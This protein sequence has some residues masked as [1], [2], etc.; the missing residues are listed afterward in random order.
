ML[1][2]ANW[3]INEFEISDDVQVLRP[4]DD[5]AV[6]GYKVREK[7]TVDGKPVSLEA[8]DASTWVK[9]GSRLL[10][11]LHTESITGDPFGRDRKSTAEFR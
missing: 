10:C 6:V 5:V 2:S 4:S 8:A 11:A 7:A 3:T 1:K 9:R